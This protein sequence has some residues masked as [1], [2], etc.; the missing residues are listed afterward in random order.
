[1]VMDSDKTITAIFA[2]N[3]YLLTVNTTGQGTVT[4]DPDQDLFDPGEPVRLTATPAPGWTFNGWSGDAN[5]KANPLNVN[6]NTH[7]NITANFIIRTCILTTSVTGSGS[8]ARV[9]DQADYDYEDTVRLTAVPAP[10][11]NF[12]GWSGDLTGS[13]NPV[14]IVMDSDKTITAI[15]AYNQYLLTVN[16]TGQGT[17]TKDPDQDLFDP[18]E[19]V[20]LTATPAPGWTFNGWSGDAGGIANPLE[21][22]VDNNK[23]ITAVFTTSSSG[24]GGG[25]SSAVTVR[26]TGWD[27]ATALK[28]GSSGTRTAAQLKSADGKL[29][30]EWSK[31]TR[32]TRNVREVV[33]A[34]TLET[35]T[36]P[37]AP[38]A[39]HALVLAYSFGPDGAAFDPAV[40][41]SFS[42]NPAALPDGMSEEDLYIAFWDGTQW[43]ALD[44]QV[45]TQTGTVTASITH[46]STYGLLGEVTP[47]QVPTPPS[48]PT[49]P[50]SPLPSSSPTASPS[51]TTA[52]PTQASPT[53]PST[54]TPAPDK[55]A[56]PFTWWLF[57]SLIAAVIAI[58][59]MIYIYIN[60]KRRQAL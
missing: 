15:F 14:N 10:G 3:Q 24:G 26:L 45:D 19:M 55:P 40:R 4:K 5:G 57:G 35:L 25:G 39:D 34:L 47:T 6:I 18:G 58:G 27:S 32:I 1:I 53:A 38:P 51:P 37:P 56:S 21:V 59:I 8:I 44:G 13:L 49:Q 54:T 52:V 33:S 60:K 43:Q 50:A 30:L 23:I 9:P 11:W 29:T 48:T 20:R 2:Y 41:L 46:F 36:D 31:G 28:T 22:T 12:I 42:Y 17:V 16:T 7:K